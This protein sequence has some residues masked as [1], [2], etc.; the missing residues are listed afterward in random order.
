MTTP[1]WAIRCSWILFLMSSLHFFQIHCPKSGARTVWIWNFYFQKSKS[2]SFSLWIN[3]RWEYEFERNPKLKIPIM[4]NSK[5]GWM[6]EEALF[7]LWNYLASRTRFHSRLSFYRPS[8]F[9]HV[10]KLLIISINGSSKPPL[11]LIGSVSNAFQ[12]HQSQFT[13]N[14]SLSWSLKRYGPIWQ[15]RI[16]C[17]LIRFPAKTMET[18]KETLIVRSIVNRSQSIKGPNSSWIWVVWFIGIKYTDV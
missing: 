17:T 2:N 1:Y 8:S 11:S 14:C 10:I 5:F 3:H 16:K 9:E 12:P 18:A 7:Q 4:A 15:W 13:G 6:N